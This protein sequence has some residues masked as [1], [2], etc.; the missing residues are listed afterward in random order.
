MYGEWAEDE[1][2]SYAALLA[3]GDTIVDVGANIGTHSVALA[4]RFP[5]SQI[6]AFEPQAL[7]FSLLS[8]N[9]LAAR[10]GNVFPRNCGCAERQT[11]LHVTPDYRIDRLEYRRLQSP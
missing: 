5:R 8:A 7:A 11:V 4:A 1:I 9:V 2:E 10:A 6:V 3:D